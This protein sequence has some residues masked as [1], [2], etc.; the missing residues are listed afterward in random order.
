MLNSPIPAGI[1]LSLVIVVACIASVVLGLAGQGGI[2]IPS[3]FTVQDTD[4]HTQG[5]Q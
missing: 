4:E 3:F 1:M 2:K 5:T